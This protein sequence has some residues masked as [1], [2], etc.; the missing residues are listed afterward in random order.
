MGGEFILLNFSFSCGWWLGGNDSY[1]PYL[2]SWWN[3]EYNTTTTVYEMF[4]FFLSFFMKGR[5]CRGLFFF[6]FFF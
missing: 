2:F 3:S 5:L 4:F 1:D 6:N